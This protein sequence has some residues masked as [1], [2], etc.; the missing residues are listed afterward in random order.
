MKK[1]SKLACIALL[2]CIFVSAFTA[3]SETKVTGVTLNHQ[4]MQVEVDSGFQLTPA[5]APPKAKDKS[6]TWASDKPEIASVSG[7]GWV[8]GKTAGNATITVTTSDGAFTA[9]CTVTVIPAAGKTKAQVKTAFEAAGYTEEYSLVLENAFLPA[10]TYTKGTSSFIAIFGTNAAIATEVKP[11]FDE[12]AQA[13][14]L[15]CKQEGRILYY[16]DDDA[17]A[18]FEAIK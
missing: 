7:T 11:I 6:V 12:K 9:S 2:L 8:D 18:I 17:V 15:T 5:I 4:E 13:N 3:C 1:I 10:Y 16:G 14:N